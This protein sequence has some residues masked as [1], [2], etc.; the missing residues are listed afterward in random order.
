[1]AEPKAE[2]VD[3]VVRDDLDPAADP[4]AGT[5]TDTDSGTETV[6]TEPEVEEDPPEPVEAA[7]EALPVGAG[8]ADGPE[9]GKPESGIVASSRTDDA[10]PAG[11]HPPHGSF[12]MAESA[13]CPSPFPKEETMATGT[14][15]SSGTC[16]RLQNP[17]NSNPSTLTLTGQKPYLVISYSKNGKDPLRLTFDNDAKMVLCPGSSACYD[18]KGVGEVVISFTGIAQFKWCWTDEPTACC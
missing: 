4:S 13:P 17:G 18:M 11:G 1:M 5:E 10:P 9:P 3:E 8:S 15:S 16:G 12:S 7:S 14:S 2:T 6:A